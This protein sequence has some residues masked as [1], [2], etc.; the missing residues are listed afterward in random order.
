M[1]FPFQEGIFPGRFLRNKN[2]IRK[3]KIENNEYLHLKT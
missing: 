1:Q 3:M 2:N